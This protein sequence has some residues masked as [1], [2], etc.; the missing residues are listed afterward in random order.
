M[1]P[2]LTSCIMEITDSN[3]T[4]CNLVESGVTVEPKAVLN[5]FL[6]ASE[7]DSTLIQKHFCRRSKK[8]H[9]AISIPQRKG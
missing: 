2:T 1:R 5:L 4:I 9:V 8:E 7:E 6:T 3:E